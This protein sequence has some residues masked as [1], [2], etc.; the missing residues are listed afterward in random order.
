MRYG[1][2]TLRPCTNLPVSGSDKCWRHVRESRPRVGLAA[3]AFKH[4][5]NVRG[6][7]PTR[8]QE[9]YDRAVNDPE[10]TSLRR[11][12]ALLDARE[13]EL[14]ERL[15]SGE[16]SALWTKMRAMIDEGASR[17]ELLEVIEKGLL[18]E[19]NWTELQTSWELRRRMVDTERRREELKNSHMSFNEIGTV[20]LF[21]AK[22]LR[23]YV[24]NTELMILAAHEME[25]F[26]RVW[27]PNTRLVGS[28]SGATVEDQG[29]ELGPE[30]E[31][32]QGP[33]RELCSEIH[34]ESETAHELSVTPAGE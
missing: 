20:G 28:G 33:E 8:Y 7:L 22:L 17:K 18:Q 1:E 4:G 32:S 23:K 10:L 29:L 9:A 25:E 15:G 16:A 21:F 13:E 12:I 24:R 5:R 3:T 34:G 27:D 26:F 14:I 30:R 31:M 19:K 6:T 11:Q 2:T